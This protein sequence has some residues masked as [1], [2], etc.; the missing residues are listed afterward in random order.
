M[1]AELRIRLPDWLL[2]YAAGCP[3][4]ATAETRM[5]YVLDLAELASRRGGGPFAAAVFERSGGRLVAAGVNMVVASGCAMAH[6]EMLAL[7]MAQRALGSYDLSA[8]GMPACEL[9]S[10]AE[11][12]LMCL[13]AILWSGVHSVVCAASDA[14]VR[15]IGFDEGPKP[16]QWA[17]RM[18]ERG[19]N[20]VEGVL[21][22]RAVAVLQAYRA[23]GGVI[24]NSRRRSV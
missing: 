6:A 20:V 12:C 23:G 4:L 7:A 18:R 19:L 8:P 3:A 22:E 21:R 24:Y 14:D 1:D 13:G 10:S 5:D 2:E 15:A 11:P 17:E 9:V 16:D